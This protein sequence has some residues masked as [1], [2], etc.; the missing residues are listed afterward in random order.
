MDVTV[1][2]GT[3]RGLTMVNLA[4]IAEAMNAKDWQGVYRELFARVQPAGDNRIDRAIREATEAE[5]DA[6]KG[7]GEKKMPGD[8]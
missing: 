7:L 6:E 1:S 2:P 3:D 8:A 5:L 4:R